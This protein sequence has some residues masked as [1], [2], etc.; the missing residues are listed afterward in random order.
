MDQ[1]GPDQFSHRSMCGVFW[2]DPAG[3][4]VKDKDQLVH[5]QMDWVFF[6]KQRQNGALGSG[7]LPCRGGWVAT[8]STRRV[9]VSHEEL[10]LLVVRRPVAFT[11]QR[12]AAFSIFRG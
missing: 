3:I 8:R 12:V 11:A 2:I 9:L 4:G 10:C 5:R 1:P 7:V 6:E